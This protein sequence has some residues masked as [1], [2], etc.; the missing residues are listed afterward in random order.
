MRLIDIRSIDRQRMEI[1][2]LIYGVANGSKRQRARMVEI[3]TLTQIEATQY[4]DIIDFWV[5]ENCITRKFEAAENEEY[6]LTH[7][8][9]LKVEESLRA[10]LTPRIKS[11]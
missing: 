7:S 5:D 9:I 10:Q 8:G 11:L 2:I 4:V 6:S 3:K 1:L